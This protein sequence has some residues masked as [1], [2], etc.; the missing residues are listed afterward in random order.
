MK[1]GE[2]YMIKNHLIGKMRQ[3]AAICDDHLMENTL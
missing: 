3:H 1:K 2:Y